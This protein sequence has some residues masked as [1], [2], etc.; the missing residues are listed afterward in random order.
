MPGTRDVRLVRVVGFEPTFSC[1]QS[2][3]GR[4]GSPY[5]FVVMLRARFSTGEWTTQQDSNL[6]PSASHADALIR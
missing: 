5:T 1:F 2:T 4:P 3:R 6:R